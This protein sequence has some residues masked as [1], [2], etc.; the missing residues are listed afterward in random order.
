M[1]LTLQ[2]SIFTLIAFLNTNLKAQDAQFILFDQHPLLLN[3]A[4]TGNMIDSANH[5]VSAGYRN[6]WSNILK[7]N[8][9]Q[10]AAVAYDH[11]INFSKGRY[12]G[13]GGSLFRDQAGSVS[14]TNQA[15]RLSVAYSVL[16]SGVQSRFS[17]RITL[18]TDVAFA[19][20]SIDVGALQMPG[21]GV[22]NETFVSHNNYAD[23]SIGLL[24]RGDFTN[25]GNFWAGFS[26]KHIN[27]PNTSLSLNGNYLLPRIIA[28]HAGS[29]WMYSPRFGIAP[30]AV[31]YKQGSLNYFLIGNEFI[32]SPFKNTKEIKSI[33]LGAWI[34]KGTSLSVS[35]RMVFK[36]LS[37]GVNHEIGTSSLAKVTG[38]NVGTEVA[39][40]VRF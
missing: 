30:S 6:Q 38:R 39:L 37:V 23:M 5:R 16:L 17:Q 9:Y 36:R 1:K 21:S 28:L 15:A 13:L 22:S 33:R 7:G 35:A 8:A 20:T 40:G 18:G 24:W 11:K 32:F 4:L 27:R 19:Q 3:P 14:L 29:T 2:I 34:L 12:L 26:I 31:V 25:K 10:T